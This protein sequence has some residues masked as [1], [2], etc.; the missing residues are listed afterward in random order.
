MKNETQPL[1]TLVVPCYNEEEILYM[2]NNA[3]LDKLSSLKSV[4][5]I[6]ED[7]RIVFVND[8]STDRT[9]EIIVSL[10]KEN[11]C[12]KGV[13]LSRNYG[14]QAALLAGINTFNGFSDCIITL[15]ADLQDDIS[16][17]D[18]MITSFID[19]CDVYTE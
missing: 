11:K 5:K 14:H 4:G 10:S 6:C 15:D 1:L 2:S 16:C 9:W 13:N 17:I 8:G 19:G 7:S 3:L 12:V 18:E